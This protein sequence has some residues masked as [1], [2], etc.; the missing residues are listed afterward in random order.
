MPDDLTTIRERWAGHGPWICN[1]AGDIRTECGGVTVATG[2]GKASSATAAA[3]H[4]PAD[5]A[6]LL[7]AVEER[8]AEIQRLR[9]TLAAEQGRPEG[10]AS[11]GWASERCWWFLNDDAAEVW[12]CQTRHHWRWAVASTPFRCDGG[13]SAD[14]ALAAMEAAD[15]W[16]AEQEGE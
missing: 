2:P 5:I 3:A 6:A 9:K 8:D 10:A 7:T 4:A 16:L 14:T 13:G 1:D 11:E 12:F 15:R